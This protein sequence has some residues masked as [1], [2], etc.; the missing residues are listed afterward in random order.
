MESGFGIRFGFRI[1]FTFQP[2]KINKIG[3]EKRV[4]NYDKNKRKVLANHLNIA[5]SQL[6]KSASELDIALAI[7]DYLYQY[8]IQKI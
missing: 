1:Q 6:N 8:L 3:F 5:T 7:N 4:D 2:I